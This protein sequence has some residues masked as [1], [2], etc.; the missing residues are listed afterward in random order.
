MLS[1]MAFFHSSPFIKRY[2]C[3]SGVFPQPFV[4]LSAFS[5]HS[6]LFS[7]HYLLKVCDSHLL[8]FSN[9]P[10]DIHSLCHTL[11]CMTAEDGESVLPHCHVHCAADIPSLAV[12]DDESSGVGSNDDS[13][14]KC[15]SCCGQCHFLSYHLFLFY[16]ENVLSKRRL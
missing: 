5:L 1:L 2:S 15:F 10:V 6:V 16:L 4:F 3:H 13:L 12:S 7:L 8:Y 9:A 11:Q 14:D